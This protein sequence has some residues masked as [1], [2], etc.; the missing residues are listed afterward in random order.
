MGP[1][2]SPRRAQAVWSDHHGLR[3]AVRDLLEPHPLGIGHGLLRVPKLAAIVAMSSATKAAR[4]FSW[5]TRSLCALR[6]ARFL[7]QVWTFL[8][9]WYSNRHSSGTGPGCAEDGLF[10][11]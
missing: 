10:A 3:A 6:F 1:T 7:S 5:K 2:A 9:V 4:F 8:I 11:E